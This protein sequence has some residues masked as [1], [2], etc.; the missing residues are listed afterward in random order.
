M[1][2]YNICILSNGQ[3]SGFKDDTILKEA[4]EA[5]GHNV[6]LE[7]VYF[8]ETQDDKWDIFIRR[9]TWVS[10]EEDTHALYLQNQTLIERLTKKGKKTINLVGNDG[11]GKG[12]LCALFAQGYQVIPT[13]DS[14]KKV[15]LLP[16]HPTYVVKNIK[17]FG[18]GLHQKF[19]SKESLHSTTQY[20]EGDIIQPKLEFTSEIQCYYVG[21]K[22]VYTLEYTPSKFP[23]YP[24]PKFINLSPE[25]Q[26]FSDQFAQWSNL[27]HGFQRVDF[28]RLLDGSLLMME[29]ED[30]AAFMNLQRL[31]EPLL[32]NV[33][34][35]YKDNIYD[36]LK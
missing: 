14:L 20:R 7:T 32:T 22:N 25:E 10:K 16:D 31:P 35:L 8:D 30:H 12:Y 29:I 6:T 9:N 36:F 27:K 1:K 28:L 26:A 19:V 21:T 5:D 11:A 4:F 33:L 23:H 3:G 18:N 24:E 34:K 17:S 15:D 2:T 13:V